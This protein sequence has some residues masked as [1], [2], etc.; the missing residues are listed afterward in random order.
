MSKSLRLSFISM[1]LI[2]IIGFTIYANSLHSQFVYDDDLLIK[3]NVFLTKLSNIK[4]LFTK[5]YYAGSGEFTYRPLTTLTYMIDYHFWKSSVVGYHLTN[6]IF[7]ILAGIA[8][9]FFILTITPMLDM[10]LPAYPVAILSGL[11]FITHPVQAEVVNSPAFRNSAI[12]AVFF[13]PALIFY[14]K[15][16]T[17]PASKSVIFY[18]CSLLCCLISIFIRE[19]ATGAVLL[20]ALIDICT[21]R[22]SA[23]KKNSNIVPSKIF[24]VYAGYILI[25]LFYA[26]ISLIKLANPAEIFKARINTDYGSIALMGSQYILY[27]LKLL[28]FPFRLSVEYLFRQERSIFE[29]QALF[30]L[31]AMIAIL[32]IVIRK[33]KTDR[34]F[35][36]SALWI[37]IFLGP[38]V[39]HPYTPVAERLLYLPCAGFCFILGAVIVRAF[40]VER[41][42]KIVISLVAALFILYGWR[43]ITRN[44]I[45]ENPLIFWEE[46][47]NHPPAT[48]RAH[49]NLGSVYEEMGLYDKAEAQFRDSI[50]SDPNYADAYND[51]GNIYFKKGFYDKAVEEIRKAAKL[52][53]DLSKCHFNLG[54]C[55]L[56]MGRYSEAIEEYKAFLKKQP[57]HLD[58]NNNLGNVYSLMGRYDEAIGQFKKAL[59]IKANYMDAW[60]NLANTYMAKG[61]YDEA[62]A[63]YKNL[64]S[65]KPSNYKARNNLS[66]IYVKLERYDEAIEQLKKAIEAKPDFAGAHYNLGNA[67][68]KKGMDDAAITEYRKA[69]NADPN[70][71]DSYDNLGVVYLKSGRKEEALE[72]WEKAVSINPH[73][74]KAQANIE[75]IRGKI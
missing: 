73:D 16:K 25:A 2:A 4:Y 7:H 20:I 61:Q 66:N 69:I 48:V 12:F 74:T 59:Q 43:T 40:A 60:Y 37:L 58:A 34:V 67:Y 65:E 24:L 26:Y 32:I 5:E 49:V 38:T 15:S 31:A 36:F 47:I 44:M 62:I 6:I 35:A 55:Y 1:A 23:D 14:L 41:Y 50:E 3:N 63:T 8:L 21:W 68:Y 13:F 33:F 75:A 11:L 39:T 46:R 53:P 28:L 51:L 71:T 29:S 57:F 30:S 19:L 18:A 42:K 56:K 45:W 70:F 22:R 10:K 54:N 52:N 27:D 64:V 17:A 72:C 9:Y